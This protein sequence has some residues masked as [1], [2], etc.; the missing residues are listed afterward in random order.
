MDQSPI[1]TVLTFFRVRDLDAT[2]DFYER[3]LGLTLERDQGSCLI[4]AAGSGYVG[5]CTLGDDAQRAAPSDPEGGRADAASAPLL[6]FVTDDVDGLYARM[7]RLGIETESPPRH[8]D[9]FGIYHFFARD[10]D[11]HR[12]EVQRFDV[13][14]GRPSSRT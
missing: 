4:F 1:E 5:F 9:R 12:L 6:T 2:R 13:P 3:D 14:L 10:P 11:G 8:D 7:R